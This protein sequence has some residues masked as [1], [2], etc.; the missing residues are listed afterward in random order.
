MTLV[1]Y[2]FL[3]KV[4]ENIRIIKRM[5][6]SV[7]AVVAFFALFIFQF[8]KNIWP[9]ISGFGFNERAYRI[10]IAFIVVLSIIKYLMKKPNIMMKPITLHLLHNN[11]KYRIYY[12]LKLSYLL[13]KNILFSLVLSIVVYGGFFEVKV[14]LTI[15]SMLCSKDFLNWILYNKDQKWL[16]IISC[17]VTIELGVSYLINDIFIL[18][19]FAIIACISCIFCVYR[20]SFNKSYY[21]AIVY[22]YQL[23]LA[24]I[25]GDTK[26]MSKYVE[27][28]NNSLFE[29]TKKEIK[30]PIMWKALISVF[31]LDYKFLLFG[32]GFFCVS[33][34][35]KQTSIADN[36]PLLDMELGKNMFVIMTVFFLLQMFIQVF[37]REFEK[38]IDNHKNGL[39]I[40][41]NSGEL[42][43][44]YSIAPIII[45]I[46]VVTILSFLLQS[47]IISALAVMIII[48]LVFLIQIALTIKRKGLLVKIAPVINFIIFASCYLLLL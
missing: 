11:D 19:G 46:I 37:Q 35:V 34:I 28:N 7:I 12:I 5:K 18:I 32:A 24:Q 47:S 22:S 10:V 8:Y 41:Y 42:L 40:P 14:F 25:S 45:F 21:K 30:Y 2:L 1:Y 39:F 4:R 36:I 27:A 31:R 6:F 44:Q 38:L 26:A 3:N 17:L 16:S 13:V 23:H 9:V 33:Y 20:L 15:L 43:W 48:S 29:S